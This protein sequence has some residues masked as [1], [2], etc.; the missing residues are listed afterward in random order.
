[1]IQNGTTIKRKNN[2]NYFG[3]TQENA[4][5]EYISNDK[6]SHAEKEKLY[7]NIIHP[8]FT[9]L[10]ENIVYTYG[11]RFQ[12]FNMGFEPEDLI[13]MG[14]TYCYQKLSRFEVDRNT[15]AYSFFGTIVKRFFIQESIK[16]QKKKKTHVNLNSDN[17][18]TNSINIETHTKLFD[19][20]LMHIEDHDDNDKIFDHNFINEMRI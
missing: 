5:K 1:M 7:V 3:K 14:V 17:T 13:S 16:I 9:K 2:K 12:F 4:I 8:A 6:L 11:N 19:K 15:K 20:N 18:T 10:T